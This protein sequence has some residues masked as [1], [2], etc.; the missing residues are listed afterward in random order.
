MTTDGMDAL[1]QAIADGKLGF[2]EA[3]DMLMSAHIR[4]FGSPGPSQS[5]EHVMQSLMHKHIQRYGVPDDFAA[6]D[7]LENHIIKQAQAMEVEDIKTRL[8]ELECRIQDT[9][10]SAVDRAETGS[11]FAPASHTHE[12][13]F[14][15]VADCA[16]NDKG[17]GR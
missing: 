2:G 9:L 11:L 3:H 17:I 8:Y 1:G 10:L 15:Q 14:Q 12:G 6:I 5:R 7:A 16:R 13:Q 4:L